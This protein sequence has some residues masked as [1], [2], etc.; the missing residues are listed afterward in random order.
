MYVN[1]SL[2]ENARHQEIE[3][4]PSAGNSV[5]GIHRCHSL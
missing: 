2:E 3:K 5:K 4:N 1:V